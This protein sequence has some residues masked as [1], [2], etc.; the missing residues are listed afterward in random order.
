MH[1]LPQ[2]REIEQQW[3]EHVVVVGV[4]T[5]KYHAERVTSRIREAA[6]RLDVAHPMVN[7]RQYRVWRSYAVR[8]WP[9][10]VI[11]GPD[12]YVVAQHAGE[13]TAAMLAPVLE[14]MIAR[15]SAAGALSGG[16]AHELTPDAPAILPGTMRYPGKIAVDG[17]RIAISDSG[18]H[19]VLAGK[20]DASG[21]SMSVEQV[22]GDGVPGFADGDRVPDA[23]GGPPTGELTPTVPSRDT[24]SSPVG[25]IARFNSPQGLCFDGDTLY[26]ADAENH[27]V[28]AIALD[29]GEVRTIAGTGKQLRTQ[30]DISA[31]AMS[32][33]W[34]I[35]AH[36]GTLYVAMA[37]IH[38]LW[39]IDPASGQARVHSGRLGEDIVDGSHAES[40]LAQPMGL[41]TDGRVLWFADAESSAIRESEID[42]AGGVRSLV[43]T[44]LFD[45]GDE[46]GIGDAVRLQHPQAVALH[47]DGRLLIADS[48]NDAL[49]WLDPRTRSVTTWVRDLHEPGGLAINTDGTV[50]VADTNAHRVLV[51]AE[52]GQ[53]GELKIEGLGG[54]V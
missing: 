22:W 8:A 36:N 16:S 21:R 24:R 41:A 35:V 17:Q 46:D 4:H 28:R 42:P 47:P 14:S 15:Y 51:L 2:L 49:K 39:S 30:A 31:G 40:L 26:V 3:A 48:Y 18:H 7:D 10:L 52:G 44:G 23:R 37:G 11:V 38:Q 1:V 29:T 34:D 54:S 6:Q 33:P 45:F 9:T 32:S 27:A 50:Y 53:P 12:G 43:G 20:L 19:R 25:A 13:Y 5:G